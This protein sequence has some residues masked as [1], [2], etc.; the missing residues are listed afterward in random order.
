MQLF[1]EQAYTGSPT[2]LGLDPAQ[3]SS[4]LLSDKDFVDS[5]DQKVGVRVRVGACVC[6]CACSCVL[7]TAS[8]AVIKVA[9]F[10]HV[11]GIS[12]LQDEHVVLG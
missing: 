5:D 2:S 6:V 9:C 12:R 1:L 3:R 7:L 10:G 11:L 4:L 8:P